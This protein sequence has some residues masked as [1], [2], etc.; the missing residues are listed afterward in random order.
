[1][2]IIYYWFSPAALIYMLLMYSKRE[3]VDLT[4]AEKVKLRK[5]VVQELK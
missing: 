1:M 2:R 3:R 4:A 5:L